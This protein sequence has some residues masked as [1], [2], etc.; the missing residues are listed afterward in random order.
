MNPRPHA[1]ITAVLLTVG[2]LAG[3]TQAHRAAG[4]QSTAA[5]RTI[6]S[7][8]RIPWGLAFLPDGTA[9][10]TER[11]SGRIL[12]VTAAGKV[13]EVQRLPVWPTPDG[14]VGVRTRGEAGLLGIAVS[15]RYTSDHWV[16]AYYTSYATNPSTLTDN[17]IVRFH[18]G[19]PPQLVL[20][21]IPAGDFHDGG[22][23]AFGPDGM[24]Y[25][26]T[27]ETFYTRDI[28][29]DPHSL[30][31]K[32]LRITPD[33]KPA[34]G[35][36]FPGSPVYSLGHRNVQGI[37]W[38]SG[39]HMY[40]SEL[41]EDR[42]DELNMIQPGHNYGWPTVEGPS[43]EPGFT[44]P[45]ASWKPTDASPSGIAIADDHIYIACLR[46]QRLYR[47]DLNSHNATPL[48]LRQYGRLRTV[49]LAPDGS[50]WILTS[51]RDGR[52]AAPDGPGQP[53]SEDDQIL[54]LQI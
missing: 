5:V 35:N 9:L 7:G 44:N 28:A 50:L 42:L 31:G 27:G 32:I 19:Q 22:R 12:S 36:P 11:D 38:D 25:A 45:I 54:R 15:P 10:V 46:G 41:G 4:G 43:N 48:L 14:T 51:N 8:L 49:G 37:A 23:I 1:A 34:P 3:C 24:L 53:K 33:G 52:A 16:Y 26:S 40:A 39:G 13:T 17:R 29:Q 20:S 6:A 47:V 21:G 18:L 30:G 2:L